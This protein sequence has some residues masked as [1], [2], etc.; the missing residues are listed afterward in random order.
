MGTAIADD[1]Y[2]TRVAFSMLSN[3]EQQFLDKFRG[4]WEGVARDDALK[5]PVLDETLVKYQ[6]PEEADKILRIQRE[7]DET[8][9]IMHDAIDNVLARGEKIDHL[10]DVSGDLSVASKGFY[11]SAKKTNSSCCVVC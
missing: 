9:I 5:F 3:V 7:I 4:Q 11:K 8:K 2:N 6:K 1:E 10:V